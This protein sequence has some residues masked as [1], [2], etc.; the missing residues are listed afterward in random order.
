MAAKNPPKK[1]IK[2]EPAS[3]L[4]SVV[5]HLR[6]PQELHDELAKRATKGASIPSL[7]VKAAEQVY[8]PGGIEAA[9]AVLHAGQLK[10]ETRAR[11]SELRHQILLEVLLVYIQTYLVS[12]PEVPEADKPA[13]NAVA[14]KRLAK[15]MDVVAQT[16]GSKA[17]VIGRS[18]LLTELLFD[19]P[20]PVAPPPPTG[21]G[22]L[23]EDDIPEEED[24]TR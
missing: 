20:P 9:L 15:L 12:T 14:A 21:G 24:E 5:L 7:V 2:A 16:V 3:K 23:F 22:L 17:S 13:A 4:G 1:S 18:T 6:V 10:S 19:E 11:K 8:L